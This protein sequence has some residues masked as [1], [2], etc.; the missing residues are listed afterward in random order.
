MDCEKCGGPI[1]YH[2]TGPG[3]GYFYDYRELEKLKRE[4]KNQ[5]EFLNTI[6]Y[7]FKRVANECP[8]HLSGLCNWQYLGELADRM[9]R[10]LDS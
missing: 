10:C 2:D 9:Q 1:M 6:K 5:I 7:Q 8:D 4:M 3:S